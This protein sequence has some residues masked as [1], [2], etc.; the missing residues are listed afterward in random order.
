MIRVLKW[1]VD[2]PVEMDDTKAAAYFFRELT[3]REAAQLL[4]VKKYNVQI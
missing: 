1:L 3:V 2:A 4:T